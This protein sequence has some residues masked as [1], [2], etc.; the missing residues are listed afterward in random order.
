MRNDIAAMVI[1]GFPNP[2]EERPDPGKIIRHE[3]VSLNQYATTSMYGFDVGAYAEDQF[4]PVDRV[5]DCAISHEDITALVQAFDQRM[6]QLGGDHH[7]SSHR[8]IW[9]QASGEWVDQGQ[10]G[11]SEFYQEYGY[12]P[13]EWIRSPIISFD[14]WSRENA[15]GALHFAEVWL[16]VRRLMAETELGLLSLGSEQIGGEH[17]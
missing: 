4:V 1:M 9:F 14:K 7:R 3:M 16:Q 2:H 8:S 15:V 5:I 11:N 6:L 17:V 13:S 12:P 10:I